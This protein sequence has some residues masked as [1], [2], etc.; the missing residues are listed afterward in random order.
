MVHVKS[1]A[2]EYEIFS[3]LPRYEIISGAPH[4]IFDFFPSGTTRFAL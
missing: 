2:L 1:G 3:G 4:V